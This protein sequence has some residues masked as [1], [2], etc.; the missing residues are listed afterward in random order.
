MLEVVR[1]KGFM[2]HLDTEFNFTDGLN[3]ITG[4]NDSGKS[5][6]LHAIRWFSMGEP[7]G[8]KF[9]TCVTDKGKTVEAKE[10]TVELVI[11]GITMSKTR[12]AN[13]QT[14]YT[15]EDEKYFKTEM[16]EEIRAC[17]GIQN[18]YEF[19]SI[20]LELNFV[21]QLDMPF[22]LSE[23]PSTGAFILGR[24]ANTEVVDIT[25]KELSTD[26]FNIKRENTNLESFIAALNTKL[27]AY[28]NL[29][30]QLQCVKQCKE[31][32]RKCY[33]VSDKQTT[34]NGLNGLL[35]TY[36]SHIQDIQ[37]KL[38]RL[39]DVDKLHGIASLCLDK[40]VR[41]TS[42]SK[43][44]SQYNTCVLTTNTLQP[45]VW[46][47]TQISLKEDSLY[48]GLKMYNTIQKCVTMKHNRQEL[49]LT[50]SRCTSQLKVTDNI[51]SLIDTLNHVKDALN[52]R[53]IYMKLSSEYIKTHNTV[54]TLTDKQI[55]LNNMVSLQDKIAEYIT[56]YNKCMALQHTDAGYDFVTRDIMEC[57]YYITQYTSHINLRLDNLDYLVN[58]YKK[59]ATLKVQHKLTDNAVKEY[60]QTVQIA[61]N[62][63]QEF[64]QVVDVMFKELG[65]CPLCNTTIDGCKHYGV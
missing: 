30:N 2:S 35:K 65:V 5:S 57:E 11:D 23:A 10:T 19:G 50:E 20:E 27:E 38:N 13:G 4:F 29:D 39:P 12:T 32:V 45:K 48:I 31:L 47:C 53:N 34:L 61:T 14:Y 37:D 17:L 8:D 62:N 33:L 3:S 36:K 43:F 44:S 15:I 22:L 55:P 41:I 56:K 6:I 9:R 25:A 18:V 59:L 64:S 52:G 60:M 42:L 40:L 28:S 46:A 24:L 58:T 21:F 49:L 54:K 51:L 63:V 7:K 1:I 26:A 16:P